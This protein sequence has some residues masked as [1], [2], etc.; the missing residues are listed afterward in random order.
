MCVCVCIKNSVLRNTLNDTIF[1]PQTYTGSNY[2]SQGN[3][4][5]R[6]CNCYKNQ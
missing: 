4:N 3:S 1:F 2:I 6:H 5:Y